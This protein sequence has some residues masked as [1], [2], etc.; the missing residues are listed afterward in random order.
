MSHRHVQP[1]RLVLCG[2]GVGLPWNFERTCQEVCGTVAQVETIFRNTM[3][4]RRSNCVQVR[5]K[6]MGP[7][8]VCLVFRQ[9]TKVTTTLL[10]LANK[11]LLWIFL[12]V[13]SG[14]YGHIVLA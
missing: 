2:A 9:P 13:N 14:G 4:E 7:V 5:K 6:S 11:R 8:Y 3:K 10:E 12:S 1:W